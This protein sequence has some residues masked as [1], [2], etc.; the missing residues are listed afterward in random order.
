MRWWATLQWPCMDA[1]SSL[2]K[3]VQSGFKV[4][5]IDKTLT[6]TF[7]RR[8]RVTGG[9]D[10]QEG[11]DHLDD[12]YHDKHPY[13]QEP[14]RTYRRQDRSPVHCPRR[15]PREVSNK[16]GKSVLSGASLQ[17]A[18]EVSKTVL[19]LGKFVVLGASISTSSTWCLENGVEVRW[20]CLI[21]GLD[22]YKEHLSSRKRCW[23]LI[24]KFHLKQQTWRL[25]GVGEYLNRGFENSEEVR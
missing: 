24:G 14:P 16:L 1:K 3:L 4:M 7:P 18:L 19:K 25:P 12:E 15:S 6:T 2:A 20:I 5:K 21:G 11:D 13:C 10:D 17:R 23:S 22:L 9:Q 8:I